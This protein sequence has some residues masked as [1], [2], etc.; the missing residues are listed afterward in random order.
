MK[1]DYKKSIGFKR[2]KNNVYL[3]NSVFLSIVSITVSLISNVIN[4]LL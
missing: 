3:C 1:L 2:T 4:I